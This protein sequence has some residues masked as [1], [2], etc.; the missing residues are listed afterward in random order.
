MHVLLRYTIWMLF[1]DAQSRCFVGLIQSVL[2]LCSLEWSAGCCDTIVALNVICV[3][4]YYYYPSFTSAIVLSTVDQLCVSCCLKLYQRE[5]GRP[6]KTLCCNWRWCH[7]YDI[8]NEIKWA[9]LI[10]HTAEQLRVYDLAL[11]CNT[12]SSG[13]TTTSNQTSG[14]CVPTIEYYLAL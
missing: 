6:L 7:M 3:W 11:Y 4:S 12:C 8:E 9:K 14:G 1:E 13:D 2:F 5:H 10:P